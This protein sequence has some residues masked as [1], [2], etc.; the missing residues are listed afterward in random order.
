VLKS[1][2]NKP[3]VV[4]EAVAL[5]F[6]HGT[7][8]HWQICNAAIDRGMSASGFVSNRVPKEL[9]K[10]SSSYAELFLNNAMQYLILL[11]ELSANALVLSHQ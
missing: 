9:R 3:N 4:A 10:V 2:R 1:L 8:S 7:W 5:G 11:G 6:F